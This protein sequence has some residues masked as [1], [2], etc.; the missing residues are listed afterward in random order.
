MNPDPS[1]FEQILAGMPDT[2][3]I[4]FRENLDI[5]G[6]FDGGELLEENLPGISGTGNLEDIHDIYRNGILQDME[7]GLLR[8]LRINTVSAITP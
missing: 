7:H 1:L 3:F 6:V 4:L 5:I 8:I 2:A